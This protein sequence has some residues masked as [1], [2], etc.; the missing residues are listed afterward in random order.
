[1]GAQLGVGRRKEEGGVR[2]FE[3][4]GKKVILCGGRSQ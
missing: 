2:N 4:G 1:M 3:I